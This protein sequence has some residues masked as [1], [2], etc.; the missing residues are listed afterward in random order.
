MEEKQ[1]K[2]VTIQLQDLWTIAKR[3]WLWMLIAFVVVA[4]L[5]FVVLTSQHVSE[6]QSTSSIFVL[7]ETDTQTSSADITV[8]TNLINDCVE[9]VKSD[10]VLSLVIQDQ[11]LA[12]TTTQLRKMITTTNETG[13]RVLYITV[14]ANDPK[15][16]ANITNSISEALC[17][18]F[19]DYLLNEQ[20]QLKII[21]PGIVATKESNPV[22]LLFVGLIAVAAAFVIYLAFFVIFLMDDKINS[23]EDVMRHLGVSVLGEIPNKNESQKRRSK[24]G[25]YYYY[26]A[27][28]EASGQKK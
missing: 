2:E 6:Y 4:V 27:S 14:T 15:E 7:R 8:A 19:N 28:E 17:S 25:Y 20:K 16:A 12:L 3:C 10:S 9:V 1:S 18:Y 5:T 24:N 21:D 26:S 23:A 22:S 13:T 11:N